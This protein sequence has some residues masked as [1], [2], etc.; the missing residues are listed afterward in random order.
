MTSGWWQGP[1][2]F[3]RYGRELVSKHAIS[4]KKRWGDYRRITLL[5]YYIDRLFWGAFDIDV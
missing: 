1:P 2:Y 5:G 4:L 3:M